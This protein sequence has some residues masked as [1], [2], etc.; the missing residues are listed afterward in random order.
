MVGKG[1]HQGRA[2]VIEVDDLGALHAKADLHAAIGGGIEMEGRAAEQSHAVG[3]FE[4]GAIVVAR[5]PEELARLLVGAQDQHGDLAVGGVADQDVAV[6][7]R[8]LKE[9]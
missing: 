6:G 9:G 3:L 7:V 4:V 2:A 5:P 1:R 8:Q